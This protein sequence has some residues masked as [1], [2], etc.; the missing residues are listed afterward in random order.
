[1]ETIAVRCP[2]CERAVAAPVWGTRG[3]ETDGEPRRY[4]LLSCP[5]CNHPF[6][7][8]QEGAYEYDHRD[9]TGSTRW[10]RPS[11][12]FP[13]QPDRLDPA[14]PENI[15]RSYLEARRCFYDASAYT[16]A[17]I[18][19][20]GTLE[21]ICASFEAKGRNLQ[22]KLADLKTRG[23]IEA[24]LHEWADDVLRALGNDAAHDVDTIIS[25]QDALDALD[26][27]KAIV[28]YLYVLEA[29]FKRF[30][31]RREKPFD[32]DYG[33]GDDDVPPF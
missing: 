32:A 8:R 21:G 22:A 10:A 6:L 19:C 7:L 3:F 24:R 1:V 14:V 12:L 27:T 15:A 29:A 11:L 28:E 13:A 31:E 5:D 9:N 4:A 33:G 17:A 20:R 2:G 26:F 23:L 18:M 25:K 30:K 16:A